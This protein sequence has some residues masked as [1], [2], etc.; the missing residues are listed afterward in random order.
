MV[1]N[2]ASSWHDRSHAPISGGPS[3]R[4]FT[5]GHFGCCLKQKRIFP[6]A[7]V[8]RCPSLGNL[9]GVARRC[10]GR[11]VSETQRKSGFRWMR[12]VG[13]LFDS[14]QTRKFLKGMTADSFNKREA[15]P[16]LVRTRYTCQFVLFSVRR[17]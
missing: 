11:N 10:G 13:N 14:A 7:R 1:V 9:G 4:R 17:R 15:A 8:R 16:G 6:L 5:R 3:G 12:S 2:G